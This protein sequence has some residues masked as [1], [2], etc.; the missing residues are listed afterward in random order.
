M[1]TNQINSIH[2]SSNSHAGSVLG[3]IKQRLEA[4]R[5][6]QIAKRDVAYLRTLDHHMLSDMGIDIAKLGE[7]YPSLKQFDHNA[8]SPTS[9]YFRLPVN[10]SPR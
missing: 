9:G 6:A 8:K 5:Q 1:Q 3:W 10:M 4:H 7:I 2:I